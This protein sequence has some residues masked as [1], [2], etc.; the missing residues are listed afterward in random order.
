MSTIQK[1]IKNKTAW[2][3]AGIAILLI[4]FWALGGIGAGL[5]AAKQILASREIEIAD[6]LKTKL[7]ASNKRAQDNE[8]KAKKLESRVASKDREI[9]SVRGELKDVKRRLKD[10]EDRFENIKVPDSIDDRV[11]RLRELGL[12]SATVAPRPK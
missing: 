10:A 2:I 6:Q 11:K 1:V 7:E 8:D 9:L 4:L 12:K 3:L 5:K